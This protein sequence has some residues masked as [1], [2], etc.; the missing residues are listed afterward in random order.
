MTDNEIERRIRG[1]REIFPRPGLYFRV[2]RLQSGRSQFFPAAWRPWIRAPLTP[3]P[4][5]P[6]IMLPKKRPAPLTKSTSVKSRPGHALG[7]PKCS[8]HQWVRVV[9]IHAV[10]NR[11]ERVKAQDLATDIEISV[12]TIHRTVVFMRERLEVPIEYDRAAETYALTQPCPFLPM[13][14]VEADESLVLKLVR[15]L[16]PAVAGPRV[17]AVH[18]RVMKKLAQVVGCKSSFVAESRPTVLVPTALPNAGEFQ[19]LVAMDHAI[20]RGEML[21]LHYRKSGATQPDTRTVQPLDFAYLKQRWV[22]LALDEGRAGAL[23]TFRLDRI[24]AVALTDRKF[25]RPADLD[26]AATLRGNIGAFTGDG[27]HEVRIRLRG[28][29]AEDA[30]TCAW[31][32]SQ[33]TVECAD[34]S[35]EV[36]FRLNNLV[37]IARCVME[38][39]PLAEVLAPPE[40]RANVREAHRA[41]LALHAE[42]REA[43]RPGEVAKGREERQ[44]AE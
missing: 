5:S 33:Q 43:R 2:G 12:R 24:Q 14:M 30:R 28:F 41:G 16:L 35:M 15:H 25:E 27:D 20:E 22:L 34:G 19:H 7:L 44:R 8:A 36:S 38:W 17:G 23:R 10:V 4:A 42:D 9:R 3:L 37:D 40:L 31:H 13:V 6:T 18:E 29:A 21:R 11:Q 32:C 1:G 39:A 26:I